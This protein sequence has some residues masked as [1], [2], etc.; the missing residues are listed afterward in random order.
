MKKT[1]SI[2]AAAIGVLFLAACSAGGGFKKT[3]SGLL[4]KIIGDGKGQ[5]A[6]RG[7][8]LKVHYT[9][10]LG[11]SVLGTSANG[12]PTYAMVDSVGPIYNPVEIFSMVRKG[13]SAVVVMMADSLYKQQPRPPF[14]KKGDK[15]TLTFRVVDILPNEEALRVDQEA[16]VDEQ[17]KKEVKQIEDYLAKNN[18]KAE[19]TQKGTFVEI[20]QQGEGPA[21]D[22]GKA[23]YVKYT[24]KTFGGKV[25]DSNIDTSFGHTDPYMLVIG[26]RGAIEGWDDG[27][28]AFKKGGKGRLFVPSMLAYGGN[29]PPG[30]PFK[31]FE[32]LMFEVEVVDVTEA[33]KQQQPMFPGQ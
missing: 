27:L 21:A 13:D 14:I 22:S 26:R 11:D 15:L 2:F 5:I 24:G 16:I 23:V 1:T 20:Q 30:A 17:K 7:Q 4:Y 25:F 9:Q 28:R 31:A 29:P 18:I 33:P 6:Q 12:M 3:K 19:K 10:K 8:F 32:N